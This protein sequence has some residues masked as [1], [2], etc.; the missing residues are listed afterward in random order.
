MVSHLALPHAPC[1][2]L[3]TGTKEY[4]QSAMGSK[5]KVIDQNKFPFVGHMTDKQFKHPVTSP[6]L[7]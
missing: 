7:K 5:H 2:K 4:T 6:I 1:I 3:A